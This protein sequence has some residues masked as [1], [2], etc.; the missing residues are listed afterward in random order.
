MHNGLFE[1][2]GVLNMYNAGMPTLRR[3]DYQHDDPLFPVKSP[4]LRPL[5]LNRQ[6]LAD[7]AAF[8]GTLEEPRHR[9]R[10][11]LLPAAP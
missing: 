8:L 6:D 5:G 1:L 4:H 9:V 2:S 10:P 3:Q 11:P 7:L